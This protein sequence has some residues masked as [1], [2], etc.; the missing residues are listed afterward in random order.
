M[1]P[2]LTT[3]LTLLSIAGMAQ[4]AVYVVNATSGTVE[5]FNPGTSSFTVILDSL[6][7]PQDISFNKNN[8]TL[9]ISDPGQ[10]KILGVSHTGVFDVIN[11]T[12]ANDLEWYDHDSKL[13]WT[14]T[15][16]QII[17]YN[18]VTGKIDTLFKSTMTNVYGL[19][20]APNGAVFFSDWKNHQL[21]K[22]DMQGN[23]PVSILPFIG[24]IW[25]IEVDTSDNKIYFTNRSKEMIQRADFTGGNLDTILTGVGKVTGLDIDFSEKKLYWATDQFGISPDKIQRADLDGRNLETLIALSSFANFQ[26]L[27]LE[28]GTSIISGS[29]EK[30]AADTRL[31]VCPNPCS[32]FMIIDYK[33]REGVRQA[34]RARLI[35]PDGK[36]Y[37][38]EQVLAFPFSWNTT[39]LPVGNYFLEISMDDRPVQSILL[40][41]IR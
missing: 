34:A 2:V 9:Y 19:A 33:S 37:K 25:D 26:F 22:T 15:N 31:I 39:D 23:G 24:D 4:S 28:L 29:L 21:L 10:N 7:A 20:I 38:S 5:L 36:I 11:N 27:G 35:S 17:R 30:T 13:L 12:Q 40:S 14:T 41:K 8:Q 6:S 18:I 32:D 3:L 16:G 1:K